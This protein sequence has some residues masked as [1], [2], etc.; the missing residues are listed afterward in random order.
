[1]TVTGPSGSIGGGGS[2]GCHG[3]PPPE[4]GS[5]STRP[6]ARAIGVACQAT[7]PPRE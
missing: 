5:T 6:R 3:G 2:G 7:S 1:M 4:T